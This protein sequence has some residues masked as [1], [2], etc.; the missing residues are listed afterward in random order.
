MARSIDLEHVHDHLR[1]ADLRRRF[2]SDAS[3]CRFHRE[4]PAKAGA[5][6]ACMNH[7]IVVVEFS[8]ISE[9][10]DVISSAAASSSTRARDA[11]VDASW[12][13]ANVARKT[14][15]Q[16]SVE[17]GITALRPAMIYTCKVKPTFGV[18]QRN[19]AESTHRRN[20]VRSAFGF[21]RFAATIGTEQ[22]SDW[23]VSPPGNEIESTGSR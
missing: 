8:P 23:E 9:C 18:S 5:I 10:K 16:S 7:C 3:A 15:K 20:K 1:L 2:G 21:G 12:R 17:R 14:S 4:R 19:Y 13:T 22:A 6:F 11:V